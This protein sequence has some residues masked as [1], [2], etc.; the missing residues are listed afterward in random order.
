MK[1][2]YL[3]S[4]AK[5]KITKLGIQNF[6]NSQ[7]NNQL[8]IIIIDWTEVLKNYKVDKDEQTTDKDER[9]KP[10]HFRVYLIM[11]LHYIGCEKWLDLIYSCDYSPKSSR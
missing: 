9:S 5:P 6:P 2:P 1:A 3:F 8:L 10:D 11:T 7:F 4:K